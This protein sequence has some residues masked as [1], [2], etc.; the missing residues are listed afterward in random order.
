MLIPIQISSEDLIAQYAMDKTE[1]EDVIDFTV[2]EITAKFYERWL[3]EANLN[4]H[5]TRSRYTNSLLLIDEGRMMGAVILDYSKDPLIKMLEEGADA[6]D[7]K[8]GFEKSDKVKYN[9]SGGWYLTI[10]LKFGAP[11]TVGDSLGGV[12]NLPQAVY[13][14][15][16]KQ[17]VSDITG[18]SS[19]LAT[20]NIP[21]Q[22]RAPQTR[23][24]IDIPRSPKFE[25][26]THK[27]SIYAGVFKQKD[28]VTGQNTYG[29]FRRVGENSDIR[30]FIHP[31]L[32]ELNLAQ[33]ALDR[34]EE[35]MEIELTRAV[36][37]ALTNFGFE[38]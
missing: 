5:S 16:K 28:S 6:F 37:S 11:D 26:Y 29:S 27:S 4:L 10:P 1:V 30:A 12:T 36:N 19:G 20:D 14:V 7:M 15:V 18:R 13:N 33:K 3:E 22:Y 17:A 23:A 32:N 31:G 35:N 2:K 24:K 9:K 38:V 34:L 25:A 8:E 21:S